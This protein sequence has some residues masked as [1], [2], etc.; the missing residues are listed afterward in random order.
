M[1]KLFLIKQ[2]LIYLWNAKSAHGVH[3]PFVFQFINEVL[4]D[5]RQYYFFDEIKKV[6]NEMYRDNT[7]LQ[8]ED[9]GAG[10]HKQNQTRRVVKDIA[11]TAGRNEKFGEL[12]FRLVNQYQ[13][14][15]ILELGTSMGLGTAYLATAN[16][17]AQVHTVEGSP[18]IAA[19]AGKHFAKWQLQ[20]ITQHVGN[21]DDVL[22]SILEQ[23]QSVDLLFVDG[24]HRK[25][26]TVAYF[27]TAKPFLHAN[28]VVIF[29]DIHWSAEMHEAWQ[30]IK[31]DSMV[32]LTID[33][34]YFGIVFFQ[35]EIQEP[36]H[37]V[38]R[39]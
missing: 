34:F 17:S 33:L 26:P 1:K 21:F 7:V 16:K 31:S 18:E 28:S 4:K 11:R 35:R 9:F 20:N 25:A 32:T 29:D 3:S 39:F 6:R 10:S 30:L 22:V 27:E 24:N 2:Y 19:Q 5:K 8:I 23:L 12:L 13:P 37:F 15:C 14:K 36:Q 38:L